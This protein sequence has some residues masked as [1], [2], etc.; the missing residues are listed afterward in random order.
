MANISKW[1]EALARQ[2][3]KFLKQGGLCVGLVISKAAK[4][5]GLPLDPE[6]L[7]TE[8]GGQVAS[9]GKSAVQKIL[10][11]HGIIKVL[12]EEGG[13]TSRGSLG[14]MREYVETL[15]AMHQAG[16]I[17]WD[18]IMAW[19]VSKVVGFFSSKGPSLHY[20]QGKSLRANIEDLLNQAD[21][22]QNDAG[23]T[24]YKGAM[25][26]H[27]VGAKL[28]LVLGPG[29]VAHHGFTVADSS[30]ARHGDYEVDEVVVHVTTNPGEALIRKCGSNLNSG[31]KPIIITIDDGVNASKY[32]LK[33]AQLC[34]RV[35][36]LDAVQ[37]LT[38]NVYEKSL[39]QAAI[40][41]TTLS[42]LLYR[43]NEI[44]AQCEANPAMQIKLPDASI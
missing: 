5:K 14:L 40:C 15:N 31:L 41:R 18:E 30:T 22:Q 10:A 24:N 11:E 43:Y 1:L 17:N 2:N 4:E 32:L 3:P 36:V 42:A 16:R 25:L 44:V 35:D 29:K 26:Q 28:D 19:W 38:A 9:L 13:R 21:E 39:F 37:F 6:S 12:A 8:E 33:N 7:R 27:L 23:G 34:D 20:D